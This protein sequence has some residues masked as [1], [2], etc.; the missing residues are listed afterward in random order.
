[1]RVQLHFL[2]GLMD[3]GHDFPQR[4]HT[5]CAREQRFDEISGAQSVLLQALELIRHAELALPGVA[6][7]IEID[8]AREVAV[9]WRQWNSRPAAGEGPQLGVHRE[10]YVEHQTRISAGSGWLRKR[11]GLAVRPYAPD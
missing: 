2:S 8:L 1:M 6:V 10:K 11:S 7:E 3:D 5:N 9:L 4:L